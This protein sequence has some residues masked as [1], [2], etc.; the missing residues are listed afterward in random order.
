M[1]QLPAWKPTTM[2]R[3]LRHIMGFIGITDVTLA[4]AGGTMRV[5]R[6]SLVRR[7]HDSST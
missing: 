7:F 4:Q 6:A 2:S 5:A 3:Y 1:T